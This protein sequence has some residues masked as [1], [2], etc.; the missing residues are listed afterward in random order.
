MHCFLEKQEVAGV[1]K[2]ENLAFWYPG[3]KHLF[4]GVSF[5]LKRGEVMAV[6]GANGVGKTTMMRCMMGFLN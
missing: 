5:E 6:L 1:I 2:A 3:S 4:R